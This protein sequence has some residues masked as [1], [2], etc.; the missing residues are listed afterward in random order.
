MPRYTWFSTRRWLMRSTAALA[1]LTDG[2]TQQTA[3]LDDD[4]RSELFAN[5]LRDKQADLT[6]VAD[7]FKAA[8][9]ATTADP[10]ASPGTRRAAARFLR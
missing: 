7:V 4:R 5:L 6:R 1:A 3:A 9:E 2:I 8:A 10:S